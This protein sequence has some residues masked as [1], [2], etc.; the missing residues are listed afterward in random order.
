MSCSVN[1][2]NSPKHPPHVSFPIDSPLPQDVAQLVP[3]YNW[4]KTC[5]LVRI[6]WACFHMFLGKQAI[7]K[8]ILIIRPSHLLKKLLAAAVR[9]PNLIFNRAAATLHQWDVY[10]LVFCPFS[11]MPSSYHPTSQQWRLWV[12]PSR[13]RANIWCRITNRSL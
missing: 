3:H 7:G 6:L 2:V 10:S 1:F 4:R 12:A 11:S 13:L 8:S 5:T 9:V